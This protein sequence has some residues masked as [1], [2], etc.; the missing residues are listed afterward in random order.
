MTATS[1]DGALNLKNFAPTII[2]LIRP[3][4]KSTVMILKQKKYYFFYSNDELVFGLYKDPLKYKWEILPAKY[5]PEDVNPSDINAG[6]NV[7]DAYFDW[8]FIKKALEK[9]YAEHS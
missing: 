3:N 9:F 8:E 5:V 4:R 2:R 6:L 7:I 1:V